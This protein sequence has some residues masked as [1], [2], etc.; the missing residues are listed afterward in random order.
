MKKKEGA[1]YLKH[2]VQ[3]HV[4][5]A[6]NNATWKGSRL[7]IIISSITERKHRP[8]A[9]TRLFARCS[10][11]Y[12]QSAVLIIVYLVD[13]ALLRILR[14]TITANLQKLNFYQCYHGAQ[15]FHKCHAAN[16]IYYKPDK[17]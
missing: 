4:I 3:G 1:R 5:V 2:F 16:E 7:A 9:E 12:K 8:S 14:R 6:V 17:G 10:C 13:M 11:I 15:I